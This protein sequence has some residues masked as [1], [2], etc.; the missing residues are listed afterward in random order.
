ME[1][2][3]KTLSRENPG[4]PAVDLDALAKKVT[5]SLR[6]AVREMVKKQVAGK[7][8]TKNPG[9]ALSDNQLERLHRAYEE[10]ENEEI[11]KILD[12]VCNDPGCLDEDEEEQ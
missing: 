7:P 8:A 10:T 11:A 9:A 3:E 12:E 6:P 4:A 1:E 5:A 2:S